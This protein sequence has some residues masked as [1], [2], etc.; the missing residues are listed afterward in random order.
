MGPQCRAA[1]VP[2]S[3]AQPEIQD[4]PRVR[5]GQSTLNREQ[6]PQ[7]GRNYPVYFKLKF[8]PLLES[9]GDTPPCLNKEKTSLLYLFPGVLL[10][11]LCLTF[12]EFHGC[13]VGL[14]TYS[15]RV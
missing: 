11:V 2:A 4:G 14:H 7:Q 12:R 6:D 3:W 10:L 13:Y 8:L 9:F 1:L 15:T 5:R